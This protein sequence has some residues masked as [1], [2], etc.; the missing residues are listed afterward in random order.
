VSYKNDAVRNK[1]AKA[2]T[3]PADRK[4]DYRG[5]S[6]EQVLKPGK[7]DGKPGGGNR[8]GWRRS[9]GSR[10]QRT[11]TGRTLVKVNRGLRERS[12]K[13]GGAARAEA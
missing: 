3:R 8:P 10:W 1:F 13:T 2:D 12:G 7:G 11:G 9:S 4:L 6:G 5:R